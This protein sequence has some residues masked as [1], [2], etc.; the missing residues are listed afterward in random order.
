[1]SVPQ[2]GGQRSAAFQIVIAA[3]MALIIGAML[4]TFVLFPVYNAFTNAAFWS[5]QT[6]GGTRLL[7]YVGGV[8]QMFPALVLFA[9]LT[10]VW[11]ST[12][13]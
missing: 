7:T 9:I 11:V 2:T 4:S 5:A 12:R 10:Y 3:F 8:W 13:Q 6:A 1:M